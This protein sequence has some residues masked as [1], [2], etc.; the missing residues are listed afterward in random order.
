[1]DKSAA[2]MICQQV[3]IE[4]LEA[5]VT[6]IRKALKMMTEEPTKKAEV[7]ALLKEIIHMVDGMG[8]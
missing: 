3:R 1:M 5:E 8:V 4:K 6:G 7:I 2:L